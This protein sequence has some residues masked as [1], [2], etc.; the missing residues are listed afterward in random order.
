MSDKKFYE[1]EVKETV[2]RVYVVLVEDEEE[3]A[4]E[5]DNGQIVDENNYSSQIQHIEEFKA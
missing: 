1:V 2:T 3:A 4:R 5:Y